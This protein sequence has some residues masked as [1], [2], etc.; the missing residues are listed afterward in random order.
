MGPTN[1]MEMGPT[2][3]MEM[4][5]TN[6]MEMDSQPTNLMEMGS[7]P[8]NLMEINESPS[9][10]QHN[11]QTSG[12]SVN[13]SMGGGLSE[14][15]FSTTVNAGQSSIFN[16]FDNSKTQTQSQTVYHNIVIPMVEVLPNTEYSKQTKYT[17]LSV[18]AA[19]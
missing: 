19:F 18:K 13:N 8:T 1:L 17:G 5:P 2:N 12:P 4:G 7:E 9:I 6:L 10:V 15:T 16:F 14:N 11:F 3:L